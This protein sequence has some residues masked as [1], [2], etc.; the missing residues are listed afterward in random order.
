MKEER[1]RFQPTR[2]RDRIQNTMSAIAFAEENAPE[3]AREILNAGERNEYVLVVVRDD[4]TASR[5]VSYAVDLCQRMQ[6]GLAILHVASHRWLDVHSLLRRIG[7]LY[8][9]LV[10]NIPAQVYTARGTAPDVVRDFV[11]THRRVVSVVLHAGEE[12]ADEAETKPAKNAWWK[13]LRCPVVLVPA[14]GE[15]A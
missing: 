3:I 15:Q 14:A 5:S 10:G 12:E 11:K 13:E 7:G 6:C 4:R 2:L 8:R 1:K 9:K